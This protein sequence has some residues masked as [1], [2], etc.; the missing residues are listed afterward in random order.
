MKRASVKIA[1]IFFLAVFF[2]VPASARP[3]AKK[4][5]ISASVGAKKLAKV[6]EDADAA[7]H[8]AAGT[9][10]DSAVPVPLPPAEA[11]A[12]PQ[13]KGLDAQMVN[14]LAPAPQSDSQD[15]S[16][17]PSDPAPTEGAF[18]PKSGYIGAQE[19]KAPEAAQPAEGALAEKLIRLGGTSGENKTADPLARVALPTLVVIA[20]IAA[21]ALLWK[22]MVS[23]G[24]GLFASQDKLR[25]LGQQ[26]IGPRS[27]ILIVEALGKKYLVGAT[28]ERVSLIA[29]LD[30][31][32]T[33]DEDS[34]PVF[35]PRAEPKRAETASMAS[36][37][38]Q[39]PGFD[40]EETA[41]K[42]KERLK[43]LKKISK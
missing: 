5:A 38:D 27:K 7:E 18:P 42:I 34:V 19:S 35:T 16:A 23:R 14:A 30:L 28:H 17:V 20:L 25:I 37:A 3:G 1:L 40:A 10:A 12:A 22:F 39:N 41:D 31:F 15:P 13:V 6:V 29:D 2:A 11:I 9:D 8:D 26:M 33:A 4:T 36:G 21:L 43:G 24:S 32:G